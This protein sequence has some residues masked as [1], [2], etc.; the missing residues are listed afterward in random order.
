ML[1]QAAARMQLHTGVVQEAL[2]L[3]RVQTSGVLK[4]GNLKVSSTQVLSL[5]TLVVGMKGRRCPN[6]VAMAER[7][8]WVK[9]RIQCA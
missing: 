1:R 6:T 3:V 7:V 5:R 9:Q 2:A 8:A 4:V